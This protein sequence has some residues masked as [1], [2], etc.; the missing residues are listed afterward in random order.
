M[1]FHAR[2]CINRKKGDL[3]DHRLKIVL[4]RKGSLGTTMLPKNLLAGGFPNH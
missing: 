1:D 4:T 2:D 3:L